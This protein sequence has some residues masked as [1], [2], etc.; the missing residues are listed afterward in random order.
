MNKPRGIYRANHFPRLIYPCRYNVRRKRKNMLCTRIKDG[1]NGGNE[2]RVKAA[3]ISSERK[4][5]YV[6]FVRIRERN[7][8]SYGGMLPP[9]R[10]I[11]PVIRIINGANEWRII[12]ISKLANWRI[13]FGWRNSVIGRRIAKF[14]GNLCARIELCILLRAQSFRITKDS[15]KRFKFSYFLDRV[16]KRNWKRNL[17]RISAV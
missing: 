12:R 13:R 6:Y 15:K 11:N 3:Y 9:S 2:K 5:L 1:K 16:D 14:N 10:V 4:S 8:T 17:N 7:D